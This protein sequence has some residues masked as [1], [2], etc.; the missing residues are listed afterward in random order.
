MHGVMR[1]TYFLEVLRYLEP[2]S[3]PCWPSGASV[4]QQNGNE[5]NWL[6]SQSPYARRKNLV[7]GGNIVGLVFSAARFPFNT[8]FTSAFRLCPKIIEEYEA[9]QA[10]R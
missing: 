6:P 4:Y 10:G 9:D 3:L 8:K 5:D 7:G 2:T 1:G